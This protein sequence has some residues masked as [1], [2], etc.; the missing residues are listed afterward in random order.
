MS[1]HTLDRK[2]KFT[3]IGGRSSNIKYMQ[4]GKGFDSNGQYVSDV[5]SQGDIAKKT[6]T[7]RTAVKNLKKAATDNG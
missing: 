6:A 7:R 4:D 2:K 3:V 5:N 1:T